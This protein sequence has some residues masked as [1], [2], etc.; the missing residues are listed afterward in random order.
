MRNRAKA[1]AASFIPTIANV[2]AR[3]TEIFYNSIYLISF[4]ELLSL[5]NLAPLRIVEAWDWVLTAR[6]GSLPQTQE[7]SAGFLYNGSAFR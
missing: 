6:E 7:L 4:N 2:H 1:T 5:E 3:K